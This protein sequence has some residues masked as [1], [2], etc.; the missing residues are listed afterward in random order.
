MRSFCSCLLFIC[1]SAASLFPED[2]VEAPGYRATY[3]SKVIQADHLSISPAKSR[4]GHFSYMDTN[5]TINASFFTKGSLENNI[6]AGVRRIH[7]GL[8][9][10][11]H[12]KNTL[13]GVLGL[14]SK[15]T[16]I[17]NWNWQGTL[18]VQ[19]DVCST[20]FARKTRYIACLHGRYA[21]NPGAGIHVGFYTELG[22]RSSFVR[23]LVGIDYTMKQWLLQ[24]VFPIKY[25]VTYQ[26]FKTNL[27]S[28]MVRPFFTSLRVHKGLYD[29]PA[30][31]KYQGFGA[32]F[33]WDYLPT[34]RWNFWATIGS[35][36]CGNLLIGNKNNNHRHHIHLHKAPYFNVGV[37][38]G[39]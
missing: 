34:P 10:K 36:L 9:S 33:R 35:T 23:P 3:P 37:T 32:E 30:I 38:F 16:G 15:Y 12:P 26:G 20:N 4:K 1:C 31:A 5:A 27:F 2:E 39:I 22:M 7:V 18:V 19:P 21:V 24:A 17:E 13:Y 8:R 28:V 25:G 11:I 29:R 14:D 6:I